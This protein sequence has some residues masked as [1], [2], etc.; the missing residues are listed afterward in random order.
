MHL[1]SPCADEE[2]P[3]DASAPIYRDIVDRLPEPLLNPFCNALSALTRMETTIFDFPEIKWD[4]AQLSLKEQVDL[5]R[6]LTSKRHFLTNQERVIDFLQGGLSRLF[7]A[8][9]KE[10]PE[11]S[12]P[13]PFTI[14]FIGSSGV[15]VGKNRVWKLDYINNSRGFMEFSGA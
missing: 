2:A 3:I 8:T 7:E 11:L 10:L 15:L 14:P 9:F 5:E 13:S 6:F 1:A 12:G 4:I